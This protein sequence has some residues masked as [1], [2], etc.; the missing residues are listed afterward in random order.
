MSTSEKR[1]VESLKESAKKIDSNAFVWKT[2]DRMSLGIPDL[3]IVIQS[4]V[5]AIE[6]KSTDFFQVKATRKEILKHPFSGP[7]VSILRQIDNADAFAFGAI[8]TGPDVACIFHPQDIPAN[9]IITL[10]DFTQLGLGVNKVDGIWRITQW[11]SLLCELR[12]KRNNHQSPATTSQKSEYPSK[13]TG[14]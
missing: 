11:P 10:D 12:S 2:N 6:A 4:F 7:Q 14:T 5:Y 3:V 13:K 9:G 1:F 8:Q